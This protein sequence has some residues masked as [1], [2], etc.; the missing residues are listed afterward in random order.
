MKCAKEG[1]PLMAISVKEIIM[2]TGA[3]RS[4]SAGAIASGIANAMMATSSEPSVS[5]GGGGGNSSSDDLAD[6]EYIDEYGVRRKK[7]RGM[8]R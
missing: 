4:E 7:R 1:K 3:I 6:D 5:P 8:R 2:I